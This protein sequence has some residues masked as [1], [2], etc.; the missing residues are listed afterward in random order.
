MSDKKNTQLKEVYD[1]V[2][3]LKES[4]LYEYRTKNDYLPVLGEGSCDADILFIGEAPGEREAETGRPFCGRAGKMLDELLEHINLNRDDVYITNILKDRPPENRDP[5]PDEIKIYTPFLRRQIS[6]IEP[7][8]IATLGR[9]SMEFIAS[10]YGVELDGT[11]TQVCGQ[12]NKITTKD[13]Q[14]IIFVP[15]LH[16]AV[17]LYD[18]SKRDVLKAD[19]E[20]LKEYAN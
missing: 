12:V 8:V 10:E 4:P 9:F 2:I 7:R 17:A 11:I 14:N 1:E 3:E 6:I 20:V 15:L 19:F 13:G 18:G 5:T 16:P